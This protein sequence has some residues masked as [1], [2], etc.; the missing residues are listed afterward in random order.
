MWSKDNT[1]VFGGKAPNFQ[2]AEN[3]TYNDNLDSA[4]YPHRPGYYINTMFADNE[5][6]YIIFNFPDYVTLDEIKWSMSDRDL[7]GPTQLF[8]QSCPLEDTSNGIDGTWDTVGV[9]TSLIPEYETKT[10]ALTATTTRWFRIGAAGA[11]YPSTTFS[12]AFAF[13]VLYGNYDDEDFIL[14]DAETVP[15]EITDWRD[16]LSLPNAPDSEDFTPANKQFRIKNVGT[17]PHTYTVTLSTA[18]E[19]FNDP[20]IMDRWTASD[21]G[22]VTSGIQFQTDLVQVGAHS[23]IIDL[24]YYLNAIDNPRDGFH[25]FRVLVEEDLIP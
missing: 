23:D 2:L 24:N 25:W 5:V 4:E 3:T 22:F 11:T 17:V 7:D 12:A 1:W 8:F 6:A 9:T 21:D 15:A 18:V 19:D 20:I 10:V 14:T 16:Y 13:I